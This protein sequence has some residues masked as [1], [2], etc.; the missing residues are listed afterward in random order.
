VLKYL[1]VFCLAALSPFFVLTQGPSLFLDAPVKWLNAGNINV[2]GSNLTLEALVHI[3]GNSGGNVISKHSNTTNTNYL[4]RAQSFQ[5][6]TTNGSAIL[7]NPVVLQSGITYHL[8][9]TYNGSIMRFYV[10]G[11]LTAEMPWSGTLITNSFATAIGQQANCQCEQFTGHLDEVRIWNVARTEAQI[12]ANMFN[13]ANP[14]FQFNLLAYFKF[15]NNFNNLAA[16]SPATS[17]VGGATLSPLPYPY[18]SALAISHTGSNVICHN[19][20]TGAID[21]Q[22]SGGLAPYQYSLDGVNFQNSPVFEDLAPGNYTIYVQSNANCVATASRNI[23]NKTP[24]TINLESSDV[25]CSGD[26]DGEASVSPTGGNGANFSTEWSTGTL[27]NSIADLA[28]GTYS[29]LVRDSCRVAGNELVVNGHFESGAVGFTSEYNN[30]MSCFAGVGGELFEDQYVVGLNANQH[31]SAFNGSGQGGGG[32]FMLVNGS[33]QANTNVWC[34]TINVEPNTYYE[35]SAWVTSIF[36]QSPAQLQFQANGVLLGPVFTAPNSVNTWSQF[37]SVWFSGANT[38]VS[39]CIINQNTAMAGNDFGIDNISF[40]ACLSCEVEEDFTIANPEI[41]T[42][43]CIPQ[44][45]LCGTASGAIQVNASGG[46]APYSYSTDGLSFTPNATLENLAPGNYTVTVQDASGCEF[47]QNVSV[48]DDDDI[49]IEAGDSPS[50]C[51][52]DPVTLSAT[53]P[54]GFTWSDGVVDGSPFTPQSTQYYVVSINLGPTCF[55]S[56]S[57]LVTVF[58]LPLVDAGSAVT[59]CQGESILLNATGAV[60][61]SWSNGLENGSTTTL[62]PGNYTLTVIGTDSNG[63]ENTDVL[64]I[65]VFP[66]P[67]VSITANPTSGSAPL[68]V[69]FQNNSGGE[70]NHTWNFDDG[71]NQSS[72]GSNT[73]YIF[74]NAG[75]Y[76]VTVAVEENGC[77]GI[78]SILILVESITFQFEVPNV[79]SPNGD[80]ENPNFVLIQL[81]GQEQVSRFELVIL[82]R[83]GQMVRLFDTPDFVWDGKDTAGNL[84]SE[85]VYFYK[86]MYQLLDNSEDT[87]HGFVHLLR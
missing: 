50:V 40:K 26:T 16:F 59:V 81:S 17:A 21:L 82:N 56:D 23:Q 20:N 53:G 34:Q 41:L 7:V 66:S 60:N 48:S 2:T 28:P 58:P 37:F 55:G 27:G 43:T 30:C 78:D 18:P 22:A 6:T 79:F 80:E 15:Q 24:I 36:A 52:G 11:C 63:C 76:W 57:V 45:A 14:N 46:T 69:D 70:L 9:A 19:S 10:N 62:E 35:F 67:N 83:W 3:V 13:I 71:Q 73:T 49:S 25:S 8:A 86:I 39:I 1:F 77:I 65:D 33:S 84:L 54:A 85:G 87:L 32:N 4:L 31:H 51:A 74:T 29:V 61:Y 64:T 5:I 75:S 68:E 38:T 47:Q 42:A 72:N 12:R 44:S